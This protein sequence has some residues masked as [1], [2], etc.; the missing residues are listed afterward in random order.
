MALICFLVPKLLAPRIC[1][2]SLSMPR[3]PRSARRFQMRPSNRSSARLEVA[4]S[5]AIPHRRSGQQNSGGCPISRSVSAPKDKKR[6]A[7]ITGRPSRR[8]SL[9]L[10]GFQ[11]REPLEDERVR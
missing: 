5:C 10:F 8:G 2:S 11:L 6:A 1:S 3:S 4:G 7:G 9:A